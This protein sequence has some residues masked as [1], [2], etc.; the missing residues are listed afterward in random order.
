MQTTTT[1]ELLWHLP[2][3]GAPSCLWPYLTTCLPYNLYMV[4]I[5]LLFT[6]D[7][8]KPISALKCGATCCACHETPPSKA[9]SW[10]FSE[11]SV[12][13]FRSFFLKA[14][15]KYI[16]QVFDVLLLWQ[17]KRK[18]L[19]LLH[20]DSTL[21]KFLFFPISR[22][23]FSLNTLENLAPTLMRFIPTEKEIINM[24]RN[25]PLGNPINHIYPAACIAP[26]FLQS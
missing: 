17:R 26:A 19:M 25:N 23:I 21:G 9:R 1:C 22:L 5:V 18:I 10:V 13:A 20:L 11:S 2:S 24:T 8:S 7:N 15:R 16:F 6:S 4:S 12:G 3:C 14:R